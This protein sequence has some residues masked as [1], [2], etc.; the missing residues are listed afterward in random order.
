MVWAGHAFGHW[1]GLG[2][3]NRIAVRF[4]GNQKL[5]IVGLHVAVT[6]YQGFVLLPMVVYH[7]TPLLIDTIVADR[8]RNS[9]PPRQ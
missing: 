5:L 9:G 8:M 7:V 3:G 6:Y 1:C 2:R 4:S